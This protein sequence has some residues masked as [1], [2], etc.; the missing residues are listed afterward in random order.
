MRKMRSDGGKLRIDVTGRNFAYPTQF[1]QQ[2]KYRNVQEFVQA[3]LVVELPPLASIA[4]HFRLN[5]S[6]TFVAFGTIERGT[7]VSEVRITARGQ[8][9]VNSPDLA[10]IM[11]N[12]G[13][14][15]ASTLL[16]AGI[17]DSTVYGS[18]T[19]LLLNTPKSYNVRA[20][21]VKGVLS[22]NP[23]ATWGT[24]VKAYYGFGNVTGTGITETWVRT[25]LTKHANFN[26]HMGKVTVTPGPDDY[27]LYLAPTAWGERVFE[28]LGSD[29]TNPESLTRVK[30]RTDAEIANGILQA[31]A[32]EYFVI[33]S[34][35]QGLGNGS[36]Y[37]FDIGTIG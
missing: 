4:G 37:S 7:I 24:G 9:Q 19:A 30:V 23:S 15:P 26:Q 16:E 33:R 32:T 31:D 22:N 1:N 21:D 8:S 13:A 34:L 27:I 36:P 28:F 12:G 10:E 29:Q 35:G 3:F 18:D 14:S 6:T 20:K 25:N 17:R 5:G 11:I 2:H